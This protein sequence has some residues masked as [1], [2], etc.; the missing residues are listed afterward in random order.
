MKYIFE[1]Y[2]QFLL[3]GM[4]CVLVLGLLFSVKDANGNAGMFEILGGAWNRGYVDILPET[5]FG[6]Y[7]AEASKEFPGVSFAYDGKIYAGEELLLTSFIK[8]QGDAQQQLRIK[9]LEITDST[10]QDRFLCYNENTGKINFPTE[11]VYQVKV[12]IKDEACKKYTCAI[13]VP[14]N[15]RG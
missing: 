9:V 15:K 1:T 2:G 10:G 6:V 14:V 12:S 11:G 3:E 4:V 13:N 7:E 8:M 5:G